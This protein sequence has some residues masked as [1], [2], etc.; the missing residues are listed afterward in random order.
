MRESGIGAGECARQARKGARSPVGR[1]SVTRQ[2]SFRVAF[3]TQN[4]HTTRSS[5]AAPAG[6][7]WVLSGVADRSMRCERNGI[8]EWPGMENRPSIYSA[9]NILAGLPAEH[10]SRLLA[11]APDVELRKSETLFEI[12]AEGDGCYL[13]NH[14][15]LKVSVASNAGTERILAILGPGAI[16]GELAMIDGLPR[17]ATVQALKDS[18]LTF[19]ARN[20][21]VDILRAHPELYAHLVSTLV[22]RLRQA[23]DEV[24]AASFLSIKARVARA[25]LLFAKHLGEPEAGDRLVVRHR[26]RQEDLAALADVARESAS[27]IMSEWKKRKI[28]EQ[29]SHSL[30]VIR[31]QPLEHEAHLVD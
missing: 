6:S 25:L 12:G 31:R 5:R 7:R 17:S 11:K 2:S 4:E 30:Y 27:R 14:G 23:D 24:A 1:P 22:A 26:I 18:R 13:L 8:G 20:V 9:H 28:I 29:Q 19:L 15:V 16:V 21:F 10:A 3:K